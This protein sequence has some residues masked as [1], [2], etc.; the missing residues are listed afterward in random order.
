MAFPLQNRQGLRTGGRQPRMEIISP[1]IE[2]ASPYLPYQLL[3]Y[4]VKV[5]EDAH[6]LC[7]FQVAD[8]TQCI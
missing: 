4:A 2:H 6:S 8:K 7:F 3:S 5:I 1:H